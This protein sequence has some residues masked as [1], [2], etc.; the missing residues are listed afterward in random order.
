MVIRQFKIGFDEETTQEP[1]QGS[2]VDNCGFEGGQNNSGVIS[3]KMMFVW[4]FC[5]SSLG[6]ILP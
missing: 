6:I 4:L 5:F 1:N 2:G 3:G